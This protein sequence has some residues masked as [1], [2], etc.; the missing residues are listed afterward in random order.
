MYIRLINI[1][2]RKIANEVN[3]KA[4]NTVFVGA[5]LKVLNLKIA[6]ALKVIKEHFTD[7]KL[8][9]DNMILLKDKFLIK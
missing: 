7:K 2:A 4:L 8:Q 5:V 3:S 1:P 9:E 6:E